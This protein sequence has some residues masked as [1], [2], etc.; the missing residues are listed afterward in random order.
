MGS[1]VRERGA[2]GGEEQVRLMDIEGGR[3]ELG[4]QDRVT[5]GGRVQETPRVLVHKGG[6]KWRTI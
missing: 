6:G 2:E 3:Q 5:G 4:M 1:G